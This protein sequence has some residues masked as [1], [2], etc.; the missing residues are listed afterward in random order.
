MKPERRDGERLGD[1]VDAASAAVRF[2]GGRDESALSGDDLLEAALVQKITVIG[3]AASK[4]SG[5][6]KELL[7]D[8]PWN[9][10]IGMRNRVVHQYWEIASRIL[11]ETVHEELPELIDRLDR[12]RDRWPADA[13]GD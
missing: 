10:M 5:E 3:E 8:L 11:W 7:N 12:S 6:T 13:E 4:V 9:D 1:I 2:L